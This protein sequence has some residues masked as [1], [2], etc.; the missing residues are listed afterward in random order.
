[1]SALPPPL[2]VYPAESSIHPAPV[3]KD[4]ARVP[5][6][7][8]DDG[9]LA[10]RSL[11]QISVGYLSTCAVDTEGRA[12]CWGAG[13][14][15]DGVVSSVGDLGNSLAV[16]VVVDMSALPVG[17]AFRRITTGYLTACATTTTGG[18]YCWGSNPMGQLGNGST[19]QDLTSASRPTAVTA[20]SGS[21]SANRP[22]TTVDMDYAGYHVVATVGYSA[23]PGAPRGLQTATIGGQAT[24]SWLAPVT[25][26]VGP[27]TQYW[28]FYRPAGQGAYKAFAR[29]VSGASLNLVTCAEAT[30]CPRLYGAP[31]AG[32]SYD[33]QILA[34]NPA[35]HGR[36]SNSV[37]VNWP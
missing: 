15:G 36:W 29:G 22:F 24:L 6:A 7:V 37:N 12:F 5:V 21:F 26:G 35:G 1:M 11:T 28:V 25:S 31:R 20:L 4:I 17:T 10:G 18:A 34:V 14:L 9:A 2:S 16:P 13:N 19:S 23:R 27:I 8:K 30:Q 33:F 32:R 3:V